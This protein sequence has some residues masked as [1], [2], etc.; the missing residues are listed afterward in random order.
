[1]ID[2]RQFNG[3]LLLA[4]GLGLCGRPAIAATTTPAGAFT[5]TLVSDLATGVPLL[6][7]GPCDRR[8]YPCST[9]KFPLAIM[10]FDA[11]LLK[12]PQTPRWEYRP[13]YK[14]YTNQQK[15]TDPT[16]WLT[17]SIVWFS[18]QLTLKLGMPR[19]QAYVDR[20]AYGNRDLTGNPGKN[21]G[22]TQSWLM[23]SLRVSPDDQVRL[24]SRFLKRDLGVAKSAYDMTSASMPVFAATGGWTVRGKTGSGWHG[25]A[26]GQ[27]DRNRPLGWFVGWAEKE[28]R[29]LALARYE[30]GA[31]P[32][33][34]PGGMKARKA[35]LDLLGQV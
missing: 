27:F 31:G 14:G 29:I 9:F 30:V 16:V 24:V 10:G 1:M 33:E 2:R 6:R 23:S 35:M 22:L 8:F 19:F 12:D 20:F 34:T 11:G 13:E 4:A 5:A 17:E 7:E 18:Q 32:A 25:S 3:A 15:A 26:A 21:D 28:G